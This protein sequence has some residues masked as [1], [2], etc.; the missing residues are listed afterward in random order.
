VACA[1]VPFP[2]GPGFQANFHLF[3]GQAKRSVLLIPKYNV[4]GALGIYDRACAVPHNAALCHFNRP[5][6]S[7]G[8]GCLEN[9][10]LYAGIFHVASQ[11]EPEAW[12]SIHSEPARSNIS[13]FSRTSEGPVLNLQVAY[14]GQ[15]QKKRLQCAC[16]EA[17]SVVRPAALGTGSPGGH[18]L[19]FQYVNRSSG[20]LRG[21]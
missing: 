1:D 7:L 20:G 15:Y 16:T 2:N 8:A 18:Y 13:A 9:G 19:I 4:D 11:I 21:T 6:P 14:F 3:L 17:V 5:S 10:E 12:D